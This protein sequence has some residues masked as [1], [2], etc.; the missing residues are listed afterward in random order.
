M[1]KSILLL[2]FV[3][4]FLFSGNAQINFI[5]HSFATAGVTTIVDE[6]IN[7][8]DIE[9]M[10]DGKIIVCG[11]YSDTLGVSDVTEVFVACFNA[12]GTL[13]LNFA[14][15]GVLITEFDANEYD[16]L[17]TSV[18]VFNNG[19]FI[20]ATSI[21]NNTYIKLAKYDD[22]GSLNTSFGD[23][24]IV[25]IEASTIGVLQFILRDLFIAAS[26]K[27][28]I[29]GYCNN[30]NTQSINDFALMQLNNDGSV[31]TDFNTIGFMSFEFADSQNDIEWAYDIE[32]TIDGN[33][34]IAG[35]YSGANGTEGAI[36]SIQSDGSFDTQFG[37]NGKLLFQLNNFDTYITDIAVD[38]NGNIVCV[39]FNEFYGGGVNQAF[40]ARLNETGSFDSDFNAIGYQFSGLMSDN[41]RPTVEIQEDGKIVFVHNAGSLI[42]QRYTEQGIPDISFGNNGIIT[43]ELGVEHFRSL[44]IA[45]QPDNKILIAGSNYTGFDNGATICRVNPQCNLQGFVF[46]D[47]N[48]NGVF[49]GTDYG[50]ANQIVKVLPGA[51]YLSTDSDGNYYSNLDNGTYEVA[52]IPQTNWQLSTGSSSYN[53]TVTGP[54]DIFTAQDFGVSQTADITDV[55]ID[56][57]S[58]AT[59]VGFPVRYWLTYTNYGTIAAD[60][61]VFLSYDPLLNY[62]YS[63]ITPD[64]EDAN[65]L[66]WNYDDLHLFENR[67]IQVNF[68]GPN[69][70]DVGNIL[71]AWYSISPSPDANPVNNQ[72][73]VF[74]EV[75]ASYDPND[76]LVS[77]R[78]IG[79]E[80]L[81]LFD[82]ELT[83]TVRFQNTGTDTAFNI[84]I[85][86]TLHADLNVE[87]FR[88]IASSHQCNYQIS[89]N[90]NDGI[91]ITFWF[92]NILLPYEDL[93]EPN[94]H[95][96]VKFA[97]SPHSDLAENTQITNEAYI[98][99]D[100]NP[101]ILTNQVL[102]TFVSSIVSVSENDLYV[103]IYPNPSS[104]FVKIDVPDII[105]IQIFSIDGK[106]IM[107]KQSDNILDVS[108]LP[109]G[110][111]LLKINTKQGLI[112]KK[113]VVLR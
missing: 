64:I 51:I 17:N 43:G 7:A 8:Q 71:E 36:A 62:S 47:E 80:G 21:L 35:K 54:E 102:N 6:A 59:R 53:F 3:S 52:W 87:T 109:S 107:H 57:T 76:K 70:S 46:Y 49:D 20:V 90:T 24:G 78:G 39:G 58:T 19:S 98:Y 79:E 11:Q 112:Q 32:E 23:G 38:E 72:D 1:K 34:I 22:T 44:D 37:N 88:F 73:S 25:S 15:E 82:T 83:Y 48:A 93:D 104:D 31:D 42:L 99:F 91:V 111:Y 85:V 12:N 110:H 67:S 101:P 30:E 86:D 74:Q 13:D 27:I 61:E 68:Y 65:S 63:D 75:I 105:N 77:P 108:D 66:T 18:E 5:D 16:N 2:T 94:S 55:A 95:G 28:V 9:Y 10:P 26:G 69:F 89:G 14:N 29:G 4:I 92:N 56:F 106:I 40:V 100:F 50:L 84:K 113:I 97:V 45:I 41:W 60:G 33:I 103:N 96:F 81:V